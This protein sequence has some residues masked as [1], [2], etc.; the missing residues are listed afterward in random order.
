MFAKLSTA[1]TILFGPV[2]D[3]DG[4]EYTGAVVGDVKI[5]KNNGT[6]AALNGSAT[7][8]SKT[9][10]LYELVLTTSD[11]SGVGVTTLVL[12]KTT[13]VAPPVRLDVLPALVYD[14]LVGGT[15]NLRVDTI[16][17]LGVAPLALNNQRVQ[18][19]VQAIDGLASAATVLGLWLAEGVQTVADSGTTTT[20]V[21]AVLT[22]A[23]GDWN[24][25]LLVFRSGT[26]AGRTAIITDF[27]AATDTLTFA[28]AVPDAVTTEG[29]VLVPGLGYADI[30]A[31]SG[32]TQSAID[33]KDF[34]DTGYNPSSHRT[35]ADLQSILL[36]PLS[37]SNFGWIAETWK[38]F[39]DTNAT[40]GTAKS[41]PDA[42]PDAA[43]GLPI[44]DAGGLDMDGLATADQ[45]GA[46]TVEYP[47]AGRLMAGASEVGTYAKLAADDDDYWS[48][49]DPDN[50][51]PLEGCV[52][53]N[54]EADTFPDIVA[55]KA[56]YN[57]QNNRRVHVFAANIDDVAAVDDDAAT[58]TEAAPSVLTHSVAG[59]FAGLTLTGYD[60]YI[61]AGTNA[62][63]GFYTVASHTD[64]ALTLDRN[65][66]SG[67][68]VSDIDFVVM[69]W[70][71]ISN[72]ANAILHKNGSDGDY[73]FSL[74][75]H[76]MT[77]DNN[78][79]FL[80]FSDEGQGTFKTSYDLRLDRVAVT[81][82]ALTGG[83]ASAEVIAAAVHNELDDHL[84][85]IPSFTGEVWYV[86]PAGSD[87][88]SGHIPTAPLLTIGAAIAAAAAGDYIKV[89]A[90]TYTETGLDLSKAG[91][92]LHGEIGA[93]L[94]PASGSALTISAQHC[95]MNV[96]EVQPAAGQVGF[97]FAT[98]ASSS[99]TDECSLQLA[100][101]M[102]EY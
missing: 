63:A 88:F 61:T 82:K 7:L 41:L 73:E 1:K 64:D 6:P 60:I 69:V 87:S 20:L 48:F 10:G 67:G 39:F 21:D 68:A 97:D 2:L 24:G 65:C 22:Q 29:Y 83:G 94:A 19:D 91:L 23:D 47:D 37:E 46:A 56:R 34:A 36:S 12:S 57:A 31:I 28:P 9:V 58:A 72:D 66:S 74:G 11:I 75:S 76:Y 85:H 78:E 81:T 40:G 4:A 43:G 86:S 100:R 90:G 50:S 32:S 98:G 17:W 93:V 52:Y 14:S 53:V 70:D 27:D 92:E 96:I 102:C 49:T 45:V 42:V 79:V 54:A 33:L 25:A 3:A 51:N 13:Y 16:Q 15:D 95:L 44:S 38:K 59:S 18:V 5:C 35:A 30:T 89:M 26:N 62:T 71:Q 77:T 99:R 80:R 101:A 84:Q 55:I 8:T